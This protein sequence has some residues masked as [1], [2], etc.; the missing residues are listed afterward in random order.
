MDT[1]TTEQ[2]TI[3]AVDPIVRRVE[4]LETADNRIPGEIAID[5]HG[6]L[7]K[8]YLEFDGIANPLIE[9]YDQWVTRI[10]PAQIASKTITI[11]EGTVVFDRL[12]ITKPSISVGD[13]VKPLYPQRC[14]NAGLTYSAS[15][16]VDAVLY[17]NDQGPTER[18]EKIPIGKIPVMLFSS[19]CHLRNLSDYELLRVGEC[20]QD[21]GGYFIIKGSERLCLIQEKLRLNRI[22]VFNG[23]TKG[24]VVC[25][26]TCPTLKGSTIVNL[27]IGK[28]R[29]IKLSLHFMGKNSKGKNNTI[30]VFQAFRLMALKYP[31]T[32]ASLSDPNVMLALV[33]QHTNPDS[34]KKIWFALQASFLKLNMVGDDIEYLA[35][36]KKIT[37]LS[38]EMKKD[39]ILSG[40]E[41]E[42]FPQMDGQPVLRKI[43]MLSAMIARLA[44]FMAGLRPLDN[45]DSW[46]NKR[47]ETAARSM[48]QLFSGLFNKVT[49]QCQETITEKRLKGLDAVRRSLSPAIIT[50]EL[51]QSFNGNWGVKGSY[52]K[53][54]I[55]DIV[56]RDNQLATISHLMRVNTPTSRQAKQPHIRLVQ[57]TQLGYICPAETPEGE[58][59]GLLKNLAVTCYISIERDETP[60][61]QAIEPYIAPD[62][63]PQAT[64]RC[65]LNGKLLGFCAGPALRDWCVHQRRTLRFYKDTCIVLDEGNLYI[66]CD[67]ARPTRPLLIV[68]QETG[69]LVI[70]EKNLWAANMQTLLAE[71]CVEYIDAWEQESI[72]LAQSIW[73][74]EAK[75]NEI[76]RAREIINEA[77]ALLEKAQRGE[78]VFITTPD[79]QYEVN[80]EQLQQRRGQAQEVLDRLTRVRWFSHCE[81]D[82]SAYLGHAASVI[83][84][85]DHNQAP[86]N[87]YQCGMGKQ[88]L[89][90]YHSNQH[91]RFDNMTKT[92][93]FPSR[94]LFEPQLNEI[95]GLNDLPAGETAIIAVMTYLGYNQ[96]DAFIFN[97]AAIERGLF[98]ML[99]HIVYKAAQKQTRDVIEYFARPEVRKGEPA[100]R[101]ANIDE[102][103]L[104]RVGA[105]V[106]QGD[107]VI[108]KV[109]RN[110][111]L[112]TV[113]NAS[114]FAGVGEEGIVERVLVTPN[115]ENMLVVKVKIRTV[116][117]PIIGDKFASRS[118]QKGTIGLIL[119]EEDMPFTAQGIRPDIIINPHCI[120]SRMTLGKVIEIAT[121]KLAALRGERMNATAH[122]PFDL[123]G[124]QENLVQY[125]YQQNGNEVM[126]SGI[127]G[128]QFKAQ[129]FVGPCYYQALRHHVLD[130]IQARARGAIKP[131][132][133]Q[134]VGGR[135]TDGGSSLR[136][137]E[138][139][140]D[141]IISWGASEF[142]KER[143]CGVSD[144]YK[145]VWCQTCGTIAIANHVTK[146]YICRSCRDQGNF[147]TVTIPY[148][149][150]LLTHLL[151]AAG[152]NMRLDMRHLG[153]EMAG[154]EGTGGMLGL[155]GE[156]VVDNQPQQT[157][158]TTQIG[159]T[160]N[161][162]QNLLPPG[163]QNMQ[164]F[165]GNQ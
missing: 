116:R 49:T 76:N 42:L 129:I 82:P 132:T 15:L 14:R 117:E 57:M 101:Y 37:S 86:R 107:C 154:E 71:G 159:T 55:T 152:L 149:F 17:P 120:P 164:V 74:M 110:N 33:S 66:Y 139:D 5:E 29:G 32:L 134:P 40:L 30:G 62:P 108:G 60:I 163:F 89:G 39:A 3:V 100:G 127:T 56:K 19:L 84:L 135:T 20:T 26:M 157:G 18:L 67:G 16:A 45:R 94:P 158:E 165:P 87:T 7:K 64:T 61:H 8:A 63:T 77:Q 145:T 122:R 160:A 51:V 2:P 9:A 12:F 125:G 83:P 78:P 112:N 80:T 146:Q 21:P 126:Y 124:L 73:A 123:Q 103:G 69:Q 59:C 133:H 98:R 52:F 156:Q 10:L 44:E 105:Y 6:L 41:H 36:K 150:K 104:I 161:I 68:N 31:V 136:F 35:R 4:A 48:E 22:F 85:P 28:R 79:G 72:L 95:I 88:A 144:A 131:I 13:E 70:K 151:N 137:G 119:N 162:P 153:Q 11:P 113:E 81:L 118:A 155:T 128:K 114:V 50:D 25:R 111:V 97:R 75:Q 142:L 130:K 43:Q 58:G 115:A 90:I 34:M 93:A 1:Q 47:L 147:G 54:N 23:D 99:K 148:V 65:W 141:A 121:S 24:N 46:S 27:A 96:E 109:R 138:M 92:L 140:R 91:Q 102:N 143:L 53:E 106:K 38:Y